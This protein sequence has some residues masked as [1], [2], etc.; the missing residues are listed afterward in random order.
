LFLVGLLLS[1]VGGVMAQTSSS[2]ENLIAYTRLA[3]YVR[4]FHPSDAARDANWQNVIGT[5]VER[6]MNASTSDELA[7]E[8]RA[9]FQ[10]YA[11][12]LQIYTGDAPSAPAVPAEATHALM[13]VHVVTGP[14]TRIGD[15]L[16]PE[17]VRVPLDDSGNL[18]ETIQPDLSF[19]SLQDRTDNTPLTLDVPPRFYET[20][21]GAGLSVRVP[22]LAYSNGETTLPV[23][24]SDPLPVDIF[25]SKMPERYATVIEIWHNYRH[26]WPYWETFEP[27]VDTDAVLREA[28]NALAPEQSRSEFLDV[29]GRLISYMPDGH[30]RVYHPRVARVGSHTVPFF[31]TVVDGQVMVALADTEKT[32]L[33][34]GDVITTIDGQPAS[35]AI[36]DRMQ[37]SGLPEGYE[38]YTVLHRLFS[39]NQGDTVELTVEPFEG[40]S[41]STEEAFVV[42]A[43]YSNS[44]PHEKRPAAV[45]ELSPGVLYV[46]TGRLEDV[47]LDEL[48]PL[49]AEADTIIFDV[50]GYPDRM[51]I[52]LLDYQT[53]SN[54][55][56]PYFYLPVVT[57]PDYQN[58]ILELLSARYAEPETPQFTDNRGY[59]MNANAAV[60]FAES[61]LGIVEGFELGTTYGQTSAGGNGNVISFDLP[62]DFTHVFSG[63]YVRQPDSDK[64][65]TGFGLE[66]DVFVERSREGVA[67]GRD[68]ILEAAYTDLTGLSADTID[69]QPLLGTSPPMP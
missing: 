32:D 45:T 64:P 11:P 66:P 28:F 14:R 4:H 59:L 16:A 46:D 6:V 5:H 56:V 23:P 2:A 47:S 61:I 9:I 37:L 44:R 31:P 15:K 38:R 50:R 33:R 48:V 18:P 17:V 68:E 52:D 40:E 12:Q 67:A 41:F 43:D 13:Y 51:M 21:I 25:V 22:L 65:V 3:G 24:E 62:G 39:G 19:E 54:I 1:A 53:K 27:Q 63:L 69:P 36:A 7:D 34:S 35:E 57:E 60:S 20:D 55:N 10:P 49:L 42:P 30:G 26:F 29:A 8:L 58:A